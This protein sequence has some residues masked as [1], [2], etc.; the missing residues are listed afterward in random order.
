MYDLDEVFSSSLEYLSNILAQKIMYQ[1]ESLQ[2][3]LLR[4]GMFTELLVKTAT[5]RILD[6]ISIVY[7]SYIR[8]ISFLE[9]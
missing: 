5:Q 6:L 9:S 1:S 4:N 2:K 8:M 7:F 3:T